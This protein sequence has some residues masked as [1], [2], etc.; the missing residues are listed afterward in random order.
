MISMLNNYKQKLFKQKIALKAIIFLKLKANSASSGP[1]LN[2]TL[3][4][5]GIPSGPFCNLFNE[6][7][8]SIKSNVLLNVS[9]FLTVTGEYKFTIRL[10]SNSFFFKKSLLLDKGMQKPGLFKFF[11]S[12]LVK[13]IFSPYMVYEIF[14]F[15]EQIVPS[16]FSDI[17]STLKKN[18]GTLRSMGFFILIDS[19]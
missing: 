8:S 2:G 5:Y 10:P 14:I 13:P 1:R 7:T 19:I 16:F 12:N 15:K 18:E 3:G 9:L 17:T 11:S 6:R 4:Q